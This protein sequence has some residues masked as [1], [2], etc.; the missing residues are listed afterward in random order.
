MFGLIRKTKAALVAELAA[1]QKKLTNAETR[2]S[3]LVGAEAQH[4]AL[5]AE[6]VFWQDQ[7]MHYANQVEWWQDAHRKV[8]AQIAGE[9]ASL[10]LRDYAKSIEQAIIESRPEPAKIAAALALSGKDVQGTFSAL[11]E[12]RP[13]IAARGIDADRNGNIVIGRIE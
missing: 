11:P 13:L 4:K 7:C 2:I 5:V 1:M 12:K 9:A 10:D 6:K 3:S 8:L